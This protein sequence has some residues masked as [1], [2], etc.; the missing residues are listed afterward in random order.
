[1]HYSFPQNVVKTVNTVRALP[2]F[3]KVL[4]IVLEKGVNEESITEILR[5]LRGPFVVSIHWVYLNFDTSCLC[6]VPTS[7]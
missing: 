1:M 6:Y 4:Q 7:V 5:T 3:K 2:E